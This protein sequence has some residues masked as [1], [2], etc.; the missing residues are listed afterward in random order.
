MVGAGFF[1]FSIFVKLDACLIFVALMI[2]I[3]AVE[4]IAFVVVSC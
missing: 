2:C 1:V 3:K 4:E